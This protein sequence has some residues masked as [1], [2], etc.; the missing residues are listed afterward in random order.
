MRKRVQSNQNQIVENQN[1]YSEAI[2][3]ARLQP[4]F[5]REVLQKT[6]QGLAFTD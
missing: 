4:I 5:D 1:R 2:K 6:R 3:S